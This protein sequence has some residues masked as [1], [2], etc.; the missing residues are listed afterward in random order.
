MKT[1]EYL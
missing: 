1:Q